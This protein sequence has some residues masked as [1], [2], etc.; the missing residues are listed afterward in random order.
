VFLAER[1]GDDRDRA[2]ALEWAVAW[3]NRAELFDPHP[4]SALY[5]D[6]AHYRAA[7]GLANEAARDRALRAQTPPRTSRDFYLIGTSALAYRHTE[8]AESAL[9]HAVA[10][11]PRRFWA[12]FSLGLCHADEG[13]FLEAAG[14]FS[15]CTALVPSF[16]WPHL[17]R[18][19]ALARAGRLTDAR[20]AYDQAL[21][22]NPHFVEALVNRGLTCL[23]LNDPAQAERDFQQ[24]LTLGRRDP[25]LRA[26]LA[27]AKARLGRRSEALRD[28]NDLIATHPDNP[29]LLVAR[30]FFFV[31]DPAEAARTA[32]EA[33]FRHTLRLDPNAARAHL[34]LAYLLRRSDS[35]AALAEADA[36]L[37]AEPDLA[38]A[39]EVR[40]LLRAR[41]GDSSARL[42]VDRLL[43]SPT[44]HRL[45]NAACA[46]AI[47]SKTDADP[48]LIDRAED[49]LQR[50]IAAGT[51]AKQAAS[52]PDLEPLR[53]RTPVR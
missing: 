53:G 38:D 18:G 44:P 20:S 3:L 34:G 7:L 29:A 40:A 52:D 42:D 8:E 13:R 5:D 26:A 21:K 48:K 24:A 45:Y 28:L 47:L 51:P 37:A 17:N 14:D 27:E 31:A 16:A 50:A 33:D 6:R 9:V 30:G 11:D 35:S 49:L 36:A 4:S 10:L 43:L 1:T 19:L 46:L 23:E 39:L 22:A 2:Q 32:A 25:A 12:W 41:L 15:A